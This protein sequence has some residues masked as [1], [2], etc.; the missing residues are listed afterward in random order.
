MLL[1]LMISLLQGSEIIFYPITN[2]VKPLDSV[3][4]FE[5]DTAET[6]CAQIKLS[7][8]EQI[9]SAV[10]Y[11]NGVISPNFEIYH[12]PNGP[13]LLSS[14]RPIEYDEHTIPATVR[15]TLFTITIQVKTVSQVLINRQ[16]D[17]TV[18]PKND[19]AISCLELAPKIPES[20]KTPYIIDLSTLINDRDFPAQSNSWSIEITSIPKIGIFDTIDLAN[21]K[22]SYFYD[23]GTQEMPGDTLSMGNFEFKLTDYTTYDNT[24]NISATPFRF[25]FKV[26]NTNDEPVVSTADTF[27]VLE[28]RSLQITQTEICKNDSDL[29]NSMDRDGDGIVDIRDILSARLISSPKGNSGTIS[30]NSDGTFTYA[31][32]GNSVLPEKFQFEIS[33]GI[34]KDTSDLHILITPVNNN[35]PKI[36]P[37][38]LVVNQDSSVI[39]FPNGET[40]LLSFVSDGDSLN[41][42]ISILPFI[43]KTAAGTISIKSDGTFKYHHTVSRVFVDSIQVIAKDAANHYDTAF[44]PVKVIPAPIKGLTVT[45]SPLN[46]VVPETTSLIESMRMNLSPQ[47][48]MAKGTLCDL[49]FNRV[50]EEA[51]LSVTVEIYDVV[52]NH[53]ASGSLNNQGGEL[54]QICRHTSGDLVRIFWN[55]RNESGRVVGGGTYLVDVKVS[56]RFNGESIET[57]ANWGTKRTPIEQK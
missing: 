56:D 16:I 46:G 37:D 47:P 4:I 40:S 14:L 22:F 15:D 35:S 26:Y 31:Q 25:T 55:G 28:N 38:T 17:V 42:T 18:L 10:V 6:K 12:V 3:T 23:R 32:N 44:I 45:V 48:R 50:I 57:T 19:N 30:V 7:D 5:A 27:T 36:I 9:E 39:V 43:G 33:D 54:I 21:G 51:D 13:Y 53:I 49:K 41:D 52:G 8:L 34:H 29:D 1:L 20:M 24:M 11:E 2:T